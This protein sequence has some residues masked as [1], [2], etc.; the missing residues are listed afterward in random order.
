[1]FW[2][3][4]HECSIFS[5]CIHSFKRPTW[6]HQFFTDFEHN[7]YLTWPF[8]F[9]PGQPRT[10]QDLCRIKIRQCIGLQSLTF[11]EDL[12][13]ARVIK[14]YLKHKF[15]NVWRRPTCTE[16]FCRFPGRLCKLFFY[17]D[18]NLWEQVH[19]FCT[20]VFVQSK[21]KYLQSNDCA[22]GAPYGQLHTFV[23]VWLVHL[24]KFLTHDKRICGNAE[25]WYVPNI[26]FYRQGLCKYLHFLSSK[27]SDKKTDKSLRVIPFD[28][29]KTCMW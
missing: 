15:D 17:F 1:M 29:N 23:C 16:R 25:V 5:K 24:E 3:L 20:S 4:Q 27:F 28:M 7:R 10:L 21:S 12:P 18:S 8:F 26:F 9:I 6:F 19:T 11:L 13:I 22:T 2:Y 14:D